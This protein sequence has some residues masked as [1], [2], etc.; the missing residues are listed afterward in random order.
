MFSRDELNRYNRQILIDKW[1]KEGQEKLQNSHIFIAG[2]GGLA[3]PVTMYLAAAGVG[4]IT[5]CDYD[6]VDISNLNRQVIH[7]EKRIGLNKADS[8]YATL[9]AINHHVKIHI[10]KEKINAGNAVKLTGNID[11][12]I[13][14][15]DN[16]PSRHYL[17]RASVQLSIPLIHGGVSGFSGQV[18]LLAPPETAC[19]SCFLPEKPERKTVPINGST[20]GVI[21]SLQA[22][23]TIKLILGKP[24]P[25]KGMILFWDGIAMKFD[26]FKLKKKAGCKVCGK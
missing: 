9:S 6:N 14:C 5:I 2:A 26:S 4:T 20:A 1:G 12:I 21:G 19:L 24:T 25:L 10:I 11:I 22:T 18:S 8:A 3:S 13:D 7:N 23:E 16:F 17:N 15:L